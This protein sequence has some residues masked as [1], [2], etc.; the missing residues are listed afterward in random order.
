MLPIQLYMTFTIIWLREQQH[1]YYAYR[2]PLP[3]KASY[4]YVVVG[5][6]SAGAIVACRLAQKGKDVLLLE[7][8][9]AQN[10]L[11]DDHPGYYLQ[12]F[13][14]SGPSFWPYSVVP[15]NVGKGSPVFLG[16]IKGRVLGGSSTKNF[17]MYNRGNRKD[18]D[19]FVTQY[20]ATGWG[21]NDVM[22]LFKLTEN[23]T[24]PNVSGIYHGRNGPIGVSSV[25][26]VS[27]I[28][29]IFLETLSTQGFSYTDVNGP[30]QAGI[31]LLQSTVNR[32]LR[33]STA[34]GYLESNICP[35]VTI[36]TKATVSKVLISWDT[37]GK[38]IAYGV[39][40]IKNLI[41]YTVLANR[42]VILSA[43]SPQI[44]MLSGVGPKDHLTSKG[45]APIYADLPVGSTYCDHLTLI[46]PVFLRQ[47]GLDP[48]FPQLIPNQLYE[49][50]VLGAGPLSQAPIPIHYYSTSVNP[51]KDYPDSNIDIGLQVKWLTYL[52][53]VLTMDTY[54]FLPALVRPKSTGTVRLN[55]TSIYDIPLIDPK[56]LDNP[57][58][59]LAFMEVVSDTYRFVETSKFSQYAYVNPQPIPGCKYCDKGPVYKCT[60]YIKCQIEQMGYSYYHPVGSCKMGDPSRPDTVVDPRLRVKGVK[61]LRVVDSSIYPT[62]INANTNAA[63]M[64]AG[65]KGAIL[66]SQ[67]NP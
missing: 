8:G 31:M 10:S 58:D 11:T 23:N 27:P 49:D 33:A 43:G 44:L 65:E 45:I 3:T 36:V 1:N 54:V 56:F 40:F 7:A 50:D 55:S 39:Q 42:E 26:N 9:G 28:D 6:G 24:D 25:S 34:T 30:I 62:I 21:Y 47:D 37:D 64:L 53:T 51:D 61:H 16:S 38:P 19:N 66:I 12:N 17:M 4:D 22:P 57:I 2:T 60:Q 67:D 32:G 18:Y 52:L 63:A 48:P 41:T 29:K 5:A 20:G 13:V 35:T 14:L 59:K 46:M 15:Q